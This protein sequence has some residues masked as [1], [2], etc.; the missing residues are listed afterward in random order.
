MSEFS[1]TICSIST[2]IGRSAIS[3][4]RVS[5]KDA[6]RIIEKFFTPREKLRKAPGSSIIHGWIQSPK[7]KKKL[8]EVLLFVFKSPSS[9]TGEDMVEISTHGGSV[10]P[11]KAIKLLIA[12]GARMAERG[13]FTRRRFLN[14]KM[15]LLEAEA[16]LDVIQ[17]KTEKGL[18]IAE[19]NLNGKLHINIEKV[20][21][22]FLEIKTLI[23]TDLDF[24]ESDMLPL[25]TQ[26]LAKKIKILQ[27]K[28]KD[29][30]VSYKRGKII[31]DGLKLAIVG[32]PNVGKSSLFNTILQ[33]DKA[34][35]TEIPGTTRD[36][37]E[38]TVDIEGYPV[39]LHDMA[40]I[41]KSTSKVEKIGVDR[42]LGIAKRSD[43]ILFIM[44]GSGEIN[45][46]DKKIF[47]IISKK[48]FVLILNKS[49]LKKKV[50][51]IPFPGDIIS[52]SAKKHLGID[53]L[54]KAIVK[55]I[56]KIIPG[57]AEEGITCTTERQKEK[58]T[59]ATNSIKNGLEVIKKGK[60]PEL[61][62]F[63]IDEAINHLKELTGEITSED[64]LDNI[65][66]NFCIGK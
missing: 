50:K 40:G 10:I 61:L 18:L 3:I 7:I 37:L 27:S 34:I 58:I 13:E 48:P 57:E 15:S 54:N 64:V 51:N 6:F 38:G 24:G 35:V 43:G 21:K 5:G 25:D 4:I 11:K 62:A 12:G 39:I 65:F 49:D 44:D 16:L 60:D 33:E 45:K 23:E 9:Y 31:L 41:R 17:A 66:S 26:E 53:K 59:Q 22:D 52:V 36:L 32:K 8:D 20:K 2:P 63:E 47:E 55:L 28:L 42:A 56:E 19:E 14:G 30:A 29:M 46:E 1:G